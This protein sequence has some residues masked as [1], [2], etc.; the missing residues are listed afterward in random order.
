M[1]DYYL[2]NNCNKVGVLIEYGFLSSNDDRKKL[3]DDN[4]L[5]SLADVIKCSIYEYLNSL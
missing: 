3:L 1:G 2:L 4:Y 5:N